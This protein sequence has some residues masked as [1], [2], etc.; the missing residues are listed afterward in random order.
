MTKKK[1]GLLIIGINGAIGT[2]VTAGVKAIN[3]N[4]VEPIGLVTE[5]FEF[6]KLDFVNL[7][8]LVI[9]GWDIIEKPHME[10]MKSHNIIPETLYNKLVSDGMDV[11]VYKAPRAGITIHNLNVDGVHKDKK[12]ITISEAIK[13]IT[14]DI[15]DFVSKNNLDG[16]VVGNLSSCEPLPENCEIFNSIEVFEKAIENNDSRIKAS[17]VY[18]YAAIKNHAPFF[19]FTPNYTIDIPAIKELA[20]RE[21]IS[22]AGNDGKTGQ[23]LYKTVIAP[24]L[25]WRNLKL[26]GWYSTNILGN[27][28]GRVLEDPSHKEAKI[29]SKS[30]VLDKILGYSDFYHRVDINYYPPRGDAKE[31]WDTVDFK[32]WLG[33]E[34]CMKINW[35]GEDST[36]AAP[37]IVDITRLLWYTQK[38]GDYGVAK[39][40]SSFFKDPSENDDYSFGNQVQMLLN[41][42]SN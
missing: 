21:K 20:I 1:I 28:D 34:M 22:I 26:F 9:G 29:K 32:G 11:T 4:Y 24:M 33:K 15:N 7:K 40:L 23:T 39:H 2:T 13:S 36:L 19:N 35:I 6:K 10:C 17:V 5:I 41:Y 30:K 25:K 37:L 42:L 31:A 3:S 8:D 16:C 14:D 12:S 18:A 38:K 27:N